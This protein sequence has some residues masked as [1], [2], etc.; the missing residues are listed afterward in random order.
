M[1][2]TID[3]DH[4]QTSQSKQKWLKKKDLNDLE[5]LL[6]KQFG[7]IPHIFQVKAI[8]AQL[9]GEDVLLHAGTGSGKT[10]F[11]AGPHMHKKMERCV[12]FVCSPL[13][14]LEEEQVNT[15]EKKFGLKAVAVNSDPE[16]C[17]YDIMQQI[18]AGEWQIVV[19][20]P[21]MIL[22]KKFI[23]NVLLNS[24]MTKWILAIVIDEAHVIVHWGS[25]FRKQYSQLRVLRALL[26]KGVL[27]IAMSATLPPHV[28]KQ[29][30]KVL[31]FG[32][33]FTDINLGND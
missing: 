33:D 31:E 27:F 11:A 21:E 14:A 22:S 7:F 29:V 3:P 18:C 15:F 24:E 28:Q 16:G 26:P 2:P 6:C 10:V 32:H 5:A 12:S 1:K 30:L 23:N 20:F 19:I 4:K 9:L 17:T 25:G 13:I 8:S